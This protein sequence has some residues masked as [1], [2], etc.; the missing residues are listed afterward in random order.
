MFYSVTDGFKQSSIQLKQ[1]WYIPDSAK[2]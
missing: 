1:S 2:T